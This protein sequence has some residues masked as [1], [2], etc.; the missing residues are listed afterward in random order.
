MNTYTIPNEFILL[1]NAASDNKT[2]W[3][4]T[5]VY[6]NEEVAV[7][8]DGHI[9][10]VRK[11][12]ENI[13]AEMPD[14]Q[15][16]KFEQKKVKEKTYAWEINNK[17]VTHSVVPKNIGN[18]LDDVTFLDYKKVFPRLESDAVTVTFDHKLLAK[19]VKAINGETKDAITLQF[20]LNEMGPI[21]VSGSDKE[22]IGIIMP[23]R[24][25]GDSP[26]AILNNILV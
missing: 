23:M 14:N 8:T 6:F 21:L 22:A 18:V 12:P 19:L 16:I 3:N 15:V 25:D 11:K 26:S 1:Q 7:A 5:G 20:N 13:K 2:R 4:L 9:L 10:A 24:P 17:R